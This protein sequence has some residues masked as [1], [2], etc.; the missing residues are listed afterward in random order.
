[1]TYKKESGFTLIEIV[2]VLV[3]LGILAAVAAPKY[4]DLQK[5]AQKNAAD[6][7][8][9]EYQARLNAVFAQELLDGK[10]CSTART[11]AKT[12]V[13]AGGAHAVESTQFTVG[14]LSE[15]GKD[16]KAT[17]EISVTAD[18]ATKFNKT[19]MVPVCDSDVT[20]SP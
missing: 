17:L 8:A 15:P 3:L 18:T 20:P 9:A 13:A 12:A 4:F 19:I 1:M 5:Q 14:T 2:M 7:V 6:A 10:T 11:D 16:G